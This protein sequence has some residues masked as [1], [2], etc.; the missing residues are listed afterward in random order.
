V[1]S[2]P[3]AVAWNPTPDNGD[4]DDNI[5]DE[6]NYDYVEEVI[7]YDGLKDFDETRSSKDLWADYAKDFR[8]R[9]DD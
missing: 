5:E 9:R 6:V 1:V 4:D 2:E 3:V 8:P 7:D